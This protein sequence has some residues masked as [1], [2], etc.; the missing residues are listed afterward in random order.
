MSVEG[1]DA[2]I[3]GP[4][5]SASMEFA[6]FT[7]PELPKGTV[8]RLSLAGPWDDPRFM[9]LNAVEIFEEDGNRVKVETIE[10]DAPETFGDLNNLLHCGA[11]LSTDPRDMWMC[12]YQRDS[13]PVNIS[14]TMKE[15]TTIAMIRIWNYSESRVYALRGVR[16]M[17]IYLDEE[18]IFS[19]EINCAF[20]DFDGKPMGDTILFTTNED[21]LNAIAQNDIF[22]NS[23]DDIP[24]LGSQ[25][26]LLSV[27]PSTS[28]AIRTSSPLTDSSIQRP[29]TG[30]TSIHSSSSDLAQL[31]NSDRSEKKEST[32]TE[33]EVTE[34][35]DYSVEDENLNG[36]LVEDDY[37]NTC[38]RG[39]MFHMELLG[40]WGFPDAIGLTGIQFL[41][42]DGE[43]LDTANCTVRCSGEEQEEQALRLLNNRNLT[44]RPDDMFLT[45]FDANKPPPCLS[46]HF[47]QSVEMSGISVWN[48]NATQELACAGVKCI[49]LYMNGKPIVGMIILRKAPGYVF[50]DYVQDI[51]FDRCHL[52]RPLSS[53]PNTNSISAFIFQIRLL[54][55]WGDEFYI[56]LNGIE[57]YNRRNH[58]VKLRPQNLAAFPES[59]NILPAVERDPRTSEK[60]IDGVNET[61]KPQHMWL[62][63]MLPN[64][65][66]RIFIIFDIPTYI[67]RVR[68]FNYRKTPTRGVR[69]V[70]ISAD[71][72]I[73]YSGEVPISTSNDTGILDVS[74]RELE[75]Y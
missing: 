23:S 62:T 31:G 2:A 66:A 24:A 1:S 20:I 41:G 29:M 51:M 33:M 55:S 63:P 39:N 30:A 68:I 69:H 74:L 35:T 57:L 58:V 75:D 50:F 37:G 11:C 59:V 47:E 16:R 40:N 3:N 53:R 19:G 60:L 48:Y 8:L 64:S 4:K 38:V 15:P 44:C 9:G 5:K 36:S 67:S 52:F 43:P 25:M 13:L 18:C 46:F 65:Y 17:K 56:G 7:I 71:D 70:A 32:S 6:N 49:Q 72:L 42:K 61:T 34:S 27:G 26:D 73:I 12:R 21:I 28:T 10:T 54:S 45:A 22:L 14:M